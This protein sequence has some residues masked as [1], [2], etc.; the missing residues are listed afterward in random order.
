MILTNLYR[1]MGAAGCV[2]LVLNVNK[3]GWQPGTIAIGLSFTT[4]MFSLGVKPERRTLGWE[5]RYL[6]MVIGVIGLAA[7]RFLL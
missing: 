2:L 4:L 5:I 6:I 1:L 3:H 7:F